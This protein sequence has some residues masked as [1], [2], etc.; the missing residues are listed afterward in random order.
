MCGSES[1]RLSCATGNEG[2]DRH[3]PLVAKNAR[4][5]RGR[6]E[7]TTALVWSDTT[8]NFYA[9][10]DAQMI[11]IDRVPQ[12]SEVGNL[13]AEFSGLA[14]ALLRSQ[15]PFDVID[16]VSLDQE[17]LKRYAAIFLPKWPA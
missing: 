4:I 16:D 10:A 13:D 5:C 2:G 15:T 17:N 9:G 11:D 12:R 7:A 6:S 8:A 14:E 1:H 3:E